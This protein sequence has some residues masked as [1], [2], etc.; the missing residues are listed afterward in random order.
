MNFHQKPHMHHKIGNATFDWLTA[1]GQTSIHVSIDQPCVIR[2]NLPIPTNIGKGILQ[3]ITLN[4]GIA[5]AHSS[6][7]F[8]PAAAG[9]LLPLAN[10]LAEAN[11]PFLAIHSI[12]T[13]RSIHRDLAQNG[14]ALP[15]QEISL[16]PGHDTFRLAQSYR[17]TPVVDCSAPCRMTNLMIWQS[18]L[19]LLIGQSEAKQLTDRLHLDDAHGLSVIPIPKHISTI[20]HNAYNKGYSGAQL[21]LSTQSKILDYLSALVDHLENITLGQGDFHDK[22]VANE[23]HA[24]ILRTTGHMPT[25]SELAQNF[26]S[27]AKKLNELFFN[28]FGK[29]IYTFVSEYRLNQAHEVISSS[30]VPLKQLAERLGYSH[31]NNF[32]AAFKRKFGYPPSTLRTTESDSD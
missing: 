2:R 9:A 10:V 3:L 21:K 29:S 14:I 24:I 32:S 16:S 23:I 20:L 7:E 22:K 27:S 31:V 1:P 30:R 26:G 4:P 28:E 11:E 13:G 6:Y 8:T 19:T 17:A 18:M 5:L 15:H 25:L 12:Q